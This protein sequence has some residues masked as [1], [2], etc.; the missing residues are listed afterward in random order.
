MAVYSLFLSISI[1][2]A[3]PIAIAMIIAATP[4]KMYISVGGNTTAGCDVGVG[5]TPFTTKAVSARDRQ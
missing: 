3:N 5:S 2:T 4:P 1:V